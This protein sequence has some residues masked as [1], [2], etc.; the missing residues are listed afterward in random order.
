MTTVTHNTAWLYLR[1]EP[2][3][4]TVG[5]YRPDGT[6]E[7]ES[8][9][10]SEAGA[11]QRVH[12]LAG[13]CQER[14]CAREQPNAGAGDGLVNPSPSGALPAGAGAVPAPALIQEAPMASLP[15]AGAAVRDAAPALLSAMTAG[16]AQERLAGLMSRKSPGAGPG[17]ATSGMRR[18][19]A[20]YA[21]GIA[22]LEKHGREFY[23]RISQ[24]RKPLPRLSA[25][26]GSAARP[27]GG[28]WRKARL[29]KE[30][31]SESN[32]RVATRSG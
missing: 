7:P 1:S 21:G 15:P 32:E 29:G 16:M 5:F 27:R 31:S 11:R 28:D 24:G 23:S 3:L 25:N 2:G 18:R 8:D 26:G 17:P 12:Y 30:G 9:H 10:P 14:F 20:A 4:W 19:E 6:W 13:G 22:C